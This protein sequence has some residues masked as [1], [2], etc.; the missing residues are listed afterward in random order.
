MDE[1][2]RRILRLLQDEPELTVAEIGERVGLSHTPCWR[3]IKEMERQGVIRGRIVLVDPKQVGFDVSVFCFV[4]LKQHDEET[5]VEFEKAVKAMPEVVQCYSM[6]GE[7]DYVLRVLTSS[8]RQYEEILKKALLKLPG[9][10]FV[11]SSFALDELK[12]THRLPL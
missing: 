5:L 12:N 7:H 2:S 3:R 10:G 11:N 4:R 8:V 1:T 6:T 9:V